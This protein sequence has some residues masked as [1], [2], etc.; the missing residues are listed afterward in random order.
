MSVAAAVAGAGNG[1]SAGVTSTASGRR[2]S[3]TRSTAAANDRPAV[4]RT[5][6]TVTGAPADSVRRAAQRA[7]VRPARRAPRRSRH[8]H[9]ARH[10]ARRLGGTAGRRHDTEG[11][12]S[13][14]AC[15][16]RAVHAPGL[17]HAAVLHDDGHGAHLHLVGREA[18]RQARQGGG[19]LQVQ[20]TLHEAE[21]QHVVGERHDAEVAEGQCGQAG[22]QGV[23]LLHPERPHPA[24]PRPCGAG[25]AKGDALRLQVAHREHGGHAQPQRVAVHRGPGVHLH[26]QGLAQGRG[27]LSGPHVRHQTVD[28]RVAAP[29][30]E[31]LGARRNQTG[32]ERRLR[33]IHVQPHDA[34]TTRG[35]AA[36]HEHG[37]VRRL[38]RRQVYLRRRH[39]RLVPGAGGGQ[40]DHDAQGPRTQQRHGP[41][42]EPAERGTHAA[43]CPPQVSHQVKR[44]RGAAGSALSTRRRN[45][46]HFTSTNDVARVVMNLLS[47]SLSSVLM[48]QY[49]VVPCR[50]AT[51]C[52]CW[53]W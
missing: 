8:K 18:L 29:R 21:P 13:A 1:P 16:R 52:R 22:G 14:Q 49:R 53:P 7:Q 30:Q 11:Q 10:A 25:V 5:T 19:A 26:A 47:S 43:Q 31:S 17:G 46:A 50:Q 9:R 48:T 6:R 15:Q 37:D 27:R 2:T 20:V 44:H 32:R 45:T 36:L 34:G 28:A 4:A 42:V 23:V 40:Q 33:V 41:G 24:A 3:S 51:M 38:V 39:R 12:G 35:A